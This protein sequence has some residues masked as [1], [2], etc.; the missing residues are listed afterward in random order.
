[1]KTPTFFIPILVSALVLS[2]CATQPYGYPATQGS[3]ATVPS[4]IPVY[5]ASSAYATLGTVEAIRMDQPSASNGAGGAI[6]G[7]VVGGLL[8]N[9]VGN[10]RGRAAATVAGVAG[11]A[12][13]GAQMEQR[14]GQQAGAYLLDVRLDNGGYRTLRQSDIAGLQVGS[15]VRVDNNAAYRY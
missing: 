6:L 5:N 7:A 10:G 15:R 1:M 8:G 4:S 13:L 2:A 3:A 11:G 14:N 12:M 9:Q